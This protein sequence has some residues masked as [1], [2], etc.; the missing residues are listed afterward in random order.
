MNGSDKANTEFVV[1]REL[2]THL[3]DTLVA[4][5]DAATKMCVPDLLQKYQERISASRDGNSIHLGEIMTVVELFDAINQLNMI[6]DLRDLQE[7][8]IGKG[9]VVAAIQ[10]IFRTGKDKYYQIEKVGEGS[11]ADSDRDK[12]LAHLLR[13][14]GAELKRLE[15]AIIRTLPKTHQIRP[16][17]PSFGLTL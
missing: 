13:E 3:M 9:H 15:L 7:S 17:G 11:E 12:S 2:K 8:A 14:H 16:Q 1:S 10:E 6:T 5:Q 4:L